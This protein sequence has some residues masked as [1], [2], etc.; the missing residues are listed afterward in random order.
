MNVP[1]FLALLIGLAEGDVQCKSNVNGNAVPPKQCENCW[2]FLPSC[3]G[4]QR[5]GSSLK[6]DCDGS[7]GKY[8][9]K[10]FAGAMNSCCSTPAGAKHM[11]TDKTDWLVKATKDSFP[12]DCPPCATSQATWKA[13]TVCLLM[14]VVSLLSSVQL[15]ST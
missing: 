13:Y 15:S 4:E 11:C 9:C 5:C 2:R 12:A 8:Y 14:C 6:Q 10:E 7:Y 1:L 3:Y